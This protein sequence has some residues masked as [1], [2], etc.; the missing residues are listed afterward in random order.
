MTSLTS[1]KITLQGAGTNAK[2]IS[3]SG[4]LYAI[5][6]KTAILYSCWNLL[7]RFSLSTKEIQEKKL[8]ISTPG[9]KS[10]SS[11]MTL[12]SKILRPF[13]VPNLR[14]RNLSLQG[15]EVQQNIPIKRK[16]SKSTNDSLKDSHSKH[17][18]V[19]QLESFPSCFSQLSVLCYH[20]PYNSCKKACYHCL[21]QRR[22]QKFTYVL[23]QQACF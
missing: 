16:I 1:R 11:Q 5:P 21:C 8:G 15:Y 14:S 18:S 20:I 22:V 9:T 13:P 23:L 19:V 3:V 6:D 10:K 2:L 7:V 12:G 17:S 4:R